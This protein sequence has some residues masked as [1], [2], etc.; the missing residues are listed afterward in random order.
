MESRKQSPSIKELLRLYRALLERAKKKFSIKPNKNTSADDETTQHE[1]LLAPGTHIQNLTSIIEILQKD[2]SKNLNPILKDILALA[3]Q[4]SPTQDEKSISNKISFD[5]NESIFKQ[6][7]G[8]IIGAE[9]LKIIANF[10]EIPLPDLDPLIQ[11]LEER[12]EKE[13]SSEQAEKEFRDDLKDGYMR[14]FWVPLIEPKKK[15]ITQPPIAIKLTLFRSSKKHVEEKIADELPSLYNQLLTRA[16]DRINNFETTMETVANAPFQIMLESNLETNVDNLT[17][18]IN[19]LQKDSSRRLK[20]I[21]EDILRLAKFA[22]A[23]ELPCNKNTKKQK[24]SEP[25]D[26]IFKQLRGM[27]I[28]AKVLRDLAFLYRQPSLNLTVFV[29]ALETQYTSEL[30]YAQLKVELL[31]SQ[32]GILSISTKR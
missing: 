10:Y 3:I 28:G 17:Q 32:H 27:I 8:M 14:P 4:T 6:L 12:H 9:A 2:N 22:K 26:S 31:T 1:N 11:A 13:T 7:R 23:A 24:I 25:G 21:L 5:F 15:I 20:P 30:R 29:K 19:I 16:K 18:I